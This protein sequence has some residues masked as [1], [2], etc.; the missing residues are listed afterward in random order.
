MSMT[1]E[2]ARAW[3]ERWKIVNEFTDVEARAKTPEERFQDLETL[4]ASADLFPP[5]VEDEEELL[6]VRESVTTRGA[7]RRR[8]TPRAHGHVVA[9]FFRPNGQPLGPR[10]TRS[11]D[12]D[13][14]LR[15]LPAVSDAIQPPT[16]I[17]ALKAVMQWL[18]SER[19]AGTIIGGVA[20]SLRGRPRYT[21]DI[22]AV[23]LADDIGWDRALASAARYGLVPRV[24]D[25]L[26]FASRALARRQK[27]W[28]DIETILTANPDLDLDHIRHHLREF[29]SVLEMPE[30]YDDLEKLLRRKK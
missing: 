5:A 28:S 11:R 20:A 4:V 8:T 2:E 18:T 3:M 6:R 10:R 1:P 15:A 23:I 13:A 9:Q 27:D 16:L 14:P 19:I 30:I 25:P 12:L 24:D 26:G 7:I 21:K 17:P 22:D 29:S